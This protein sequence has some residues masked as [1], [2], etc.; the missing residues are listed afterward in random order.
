MLRSETMAT[1][2]TFFDV[3][4][5][6]NGFRVDIVWFIF[7]GLTLLTCNGFVLFVLK[8]C[9]KRQNYFKITSGTLRSG[10]SVALCLLIFGKFSRGYTLIKGGY[11]Y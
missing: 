11:G 9:L 10:I 6:I 4:F 2:I 8:F 1:Y 7:N 5:S 3:D